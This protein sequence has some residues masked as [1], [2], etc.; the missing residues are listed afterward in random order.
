[1]IKLLELYIKS[2]LIFNNILVFTVGNNGYGGSLIK[3][4][5]DIENI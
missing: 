3:N 5:K 4:Y 2:M 1:M